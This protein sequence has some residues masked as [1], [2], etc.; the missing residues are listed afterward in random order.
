[1]I[2]VKDFSTFIRI[3]S[4]FKSER[5]RAYIKLTRHRAL[6]RSVMTYACPAW[7]LATDAH[8][9]KLQRL[10]KKVLRTIIN[11]SRSIQVRDLR[12]A[13]NLPYVYDYITKLCR[14]QAE[15]IRNHEN[16]HVR[17]IGQGE[18]RHRK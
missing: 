5:L 7:E 14:R 18:A 8:L 1:M 6:I 16:E 9:L 10:Q 15:V 4:L 11:F 13:F 17:I 12:T 2:E 3:Y